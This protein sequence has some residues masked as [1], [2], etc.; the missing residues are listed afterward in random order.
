MSYFVTV[1]DVVFIFDKFE[2]AYNY[3]K[4]ENGLLFKAVPIIDFRRG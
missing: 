1:R 2:D 4:K 3:A